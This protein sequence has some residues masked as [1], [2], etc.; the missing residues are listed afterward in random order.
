MRLFL[1]VLFLFF[2][3]TGTATA[4]VHPYFAGAVGSGFMGNTDLLSSGGTF[5]DYATYQQGSPKASAI[6]IVSDYRRFELSYIQQLSAVDTLMNTKPASGVNL[7][8]NSIMGNVY[9]DFP[10]KSGFLWYLMTGI[11]SSEVSIITSSSVLRDKVFTWQAGG[12]IGLKVSKHLL[13]DCGYRY[14]K[15]SNLTL[16]GVD[17]TYASHN[18]MVGSR[19]SF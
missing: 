8:I 6:G 1:S 3:V 7:S 18:V 16:F 11:G 19:F 4:S 17:L 12:G 15:P 9:R 2:F 13:I 14:I 5:S 10:Q